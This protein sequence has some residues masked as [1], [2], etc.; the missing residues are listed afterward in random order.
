MYVIKKWHIAIET[1]ESALGLI[2]ICAYFL[3]SYV[4]NSK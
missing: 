4:S 1:I 3:L 2:G